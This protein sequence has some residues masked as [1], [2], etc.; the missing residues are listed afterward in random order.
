MIAPQKISIFLPSLVGGGAERVMIYLAN[1]FVSSGIAVDLVLVSVEGEYLS[2]VS[3]QVRIVDLNASRV[4][5]SLPR[6][7]E[8]LNREKPDVVLSAMHHINI[9]A[10]LA[11]RLAKLK[12]KLVVSI[13][14]HSSSTFFRDRRT[15]VR[16]MILF[17]LIKIFYDIPDRIV[18]VS[19]DV[20]KDLKAIL[21]KIPEKKLIAIYNPV[22]LPEIF[23]KAGESVSHPWILTGSPIVLGVGRLTEQKDFST[24]IR[25]FAKVSQSQTVQL[26]ILGE[27]EKREQLTSLVNSLGLTGRVS[28]P[29][30]VDNPFAY[31]RQASVFVLSSQWEGLPTALIEAMACGAAVV[32]TNCPNG[33]REILEDGKWGKLV[34]VGDVEAMAEAILDS[35]R[36]NTKCPPRELLESRFGLNAITDQYLSVLL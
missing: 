3:Q 27:G 9:V 32:S 31:M 4:L 2:L 24:L 17:Q 21:P 10:A 6:L 12:T 22:V 35:L 33:P 13:H 23:L 30:F 8:Y 14:N 5:F 20:V 25:A 36:G 7:V 34:P 29:G 1:G 28:L 16:S 19:E 26:I 18:G 11:C 15:P